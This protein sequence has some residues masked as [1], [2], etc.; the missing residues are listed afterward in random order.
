MTSIGPS[1][2]KEKKKSGGPTLLH[3]ALFIIAALLIGAIL[4]YT[5]L[6]DAIGLFL[7]STMR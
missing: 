7:L 2:R 6:I 4:V 3:F 1:E 5:G